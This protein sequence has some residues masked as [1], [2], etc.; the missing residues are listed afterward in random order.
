MTSAPVSI[1][2]A[3]GAHALARAVAACLSARQGRYA[4]SVGAFALALTMPMI[5]QAAT[6]TV[7]NTDDAGPGSLRQAIEDANTS[8]GADEIRFAVSVVGTIALSDTL[9]VTDSVS[10]QGPGQELLTLDGGGGDVGVF[11][12]FCPEGQHTVSLSG[13]TIAN[14]AW[15]ISGGTENLVNAHLEIAVAESIVT[16]HSGTGIAITPGFYSGGAALAI[17]ES[18]ISGNDGNGVTL[19]STRSGYAT[20]TIARTT[21]IGNSGDG[22][23]AVGMTYE[24]ARVGIAESVISGNAGSGVYAAEASVQIA[25]SAINENS[26]GIR[27]DI[28]RDGE[29]P[30]LTESVISGNA[31][32]GLEIRSSAGA[33]VTGCTI[34]GNGG[35]GIDLP[36]YYSSVSLEASAVTENGNGGIRSVSGSGLSIVNSTLSGN[37]GAPAVKFGLDGRVRSSTIVNNPAGGIVGRFDQYIS[38]ISGSIIAGNG[39]SSEAD[40]AGRFSVDY[41]LIQNPGTAEIIETTANSNLIGQ[42]PLLGPLQDNGGPT[43]THALLAGSPAI[44]G[45]DPAFVPPPETDQRGAGFPRVEGWQ[46]DMGAYELQASQPDAVRYLGVA[47]IAD[48]NGTGTPELA[49]LQVHTDDTAS[50]VIKDSATNRVVNTLTFASAGSTPLG[51]TG[52]DLGYGGVGVAVLF[53]RPDGQGLVQIRDADTGELVREMTF[54]REWTATAIAAADVNLDGVSEIALLGV[55]QDGERA[56]LGVRHATTGALLYGMDLPMSG[57]GTRYL[58][59]TSLPE[60]PELAALRTLADGTPQVIVVDPAT[61]QVLSELEVKQFIGIP[62]GLT[63]LADRNANGYPEVAVLFRKP[64]GQGLVKVKDSATDAWVNGLQFFGADW[65]TT[66]ITTLDHDGVPALSV[67]AVKQDD[68]AAAAQTLDAISRRQV[69]WVSFPVD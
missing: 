14:A 33:S 56:G 54:S 59:L 34:A 5:G 61:R 21:I 25:D 29:G 18:V 49:A 31:E 3:S 7:T 11:D 35:V 30:I 62:K 60:T 38:H 10:I 26:V 45:G 58:D 39:A 67:L 52:L 69:N 41:S 40:L 50:V 43:L 48:L 24:G 27:I 1:Q 17:N 23:Q 19:S 68:T 42:D 57:A 46:I 55:H 6:F 36:S 8:P 63:G 64:N 28:V 12:I 66:A 22:V 51:V 32:A 9:R 20:A 16:G 53:Q 47:S 37:M 4:V 44:D 65:Q 13:L 2:H 15:G